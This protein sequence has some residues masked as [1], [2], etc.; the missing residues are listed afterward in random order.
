M[1]TRSDHHNGQFG[2]QINP[3]IDLPQKGW[4][5]H[6]NVQLPSKMIVTVLDDLH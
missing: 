3:D 4:D 5:V 1:A 2:Q 6:H